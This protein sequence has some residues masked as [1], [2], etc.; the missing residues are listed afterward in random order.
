MKTVTLLAELQ[1]LDMRIDE[2]AVVRADLEKKLADDAEVAAAIA[3]RQVSEQRTADLKAQL[4]ALE[5]ETQSVAEHVKQLSERLYSGRI[6]NAKELAGLNQDEKMLQRHQSTLEDQELELMEQIEAAERDARAKRKEWEDAAA[7][8]EAQS[9]QARAALAETE[10][11]DRELM[12][13]REALRA[14]LAVDALAVYDELR[15]TKKGRAVAPIKGT[16][17]AAC[18]FAVPSGLI[19]RANLGDELVFCTNCG[20]IL[21]P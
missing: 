18:G 16:S 15:R 10:R 7:R 17:C 3:A 11:A 9:R 19:S 20:R 2:N 6:T 4:R 5:L 8:Y 13:R 1:N 12:R 14:Q 21:A